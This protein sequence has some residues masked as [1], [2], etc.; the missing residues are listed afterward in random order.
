MK[1][2]CEDGAAAQA[3]R[4]KL[5]LSQAD[6]WGRVGVVQSGGSHYESGRTIPIQLAWALH[7]VYGT[8]AQAKELTR[9]I[10]GQM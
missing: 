3:L 8:E 2:L 5:G 6:F 9:R 7:I 10:R 1:L 4:R